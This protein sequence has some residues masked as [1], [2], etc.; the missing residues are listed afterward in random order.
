MSSEFARGHVHIQ[1]TASAT[2]TIVHGLDTTEIGVDVF[3]DVN[4]VL[5]KILPK[6]VQITDTKTVVI[7]FSTAKTGEAFVF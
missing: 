2:W 1:Q 4:G 3:V 7:T 5:T 6:N